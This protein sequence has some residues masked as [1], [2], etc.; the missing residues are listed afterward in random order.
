M[1]ADSEG[2]VWFRHGHRVFTRP[3]SLWDSIAGYRPW[4]HWAVAAEDVERAYLI[5]AAP[6]LLD[7]CEAMLHGDNDAIRQMK[8]AVAA[9]KPA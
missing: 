4:T 5:A 6:A 3:T 8:R 1:D 9:A 2:V 7:A